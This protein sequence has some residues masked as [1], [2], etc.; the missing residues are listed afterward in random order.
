M[1]YASGRTPKAIVEAYGLASVGVLGNI[2]A[3]PR[4]A[5]WVEAYKEEIASATIQ[6]AVKKRL[7]AKLSMD[8]LY[9]Y[10][11]DAPI[12]SGKAIKVR[13]WFV[14]GEDRSRRFNDAEAAGPKP[15]SMDLVVRLEQSTRPLLEQPVID[16]S[17]EDTH[18]HSGKQF[19]DKRDRQLAALGSVSEAE[20]TNG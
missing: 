9:R 6:Y 19:M 3:K 13:Q 18:L 1:D 5:R 20:I 17:P 2:L 15:I 7:A 16:I 14:D 4:V 11:E 8:Q 12:E 10:I